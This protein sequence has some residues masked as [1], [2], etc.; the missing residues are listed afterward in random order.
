M[1]NGTARFASV[2][3]KSER[4]CRPGLLY[5]SLQVAHT[6]RAVWITVKKRKVH[7]LLM[8]SYKSRRCHEEISI[9]CVGIIFVSRRISSGRW[10]QV[11][12]RSPTFCQLD[13]IHSAILPLKQHKEDY[14]QFCPPI[15]VVAS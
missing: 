12:Y 9:T 1:I 4:T 5:P 2:T 11:L 3:R 14:S 15:W 10:D 13:G 6:W 7:L 8:L